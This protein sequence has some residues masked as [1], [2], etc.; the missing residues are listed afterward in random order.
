MAM[1]TESCVCNGLNNIWCCG[2]GGGDTN[3]LVVPHY[4]MTKD[5]SNPS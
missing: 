5:G 4:K 1:R 2:N 3:I